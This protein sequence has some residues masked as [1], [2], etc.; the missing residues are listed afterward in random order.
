M[1]IFDIEQFQFVLKVY[2]CAFR[3]LQQ[4]P[5]FLR[6]SPNVF[7]S[8]LHIPVGCQVSGMFDFSWPGD[9]EGAFLLDEGVMSVNHYRDII[10][11]RGGVEA[12]PD[13]GE[14]A[15]VNN[16]YLASFIIEN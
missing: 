2:E 7:Q 3:K 15:Q 13:P 14:Y 12:G 16:S 10:T 9:T 11:F 4:V 8:C 1:K 5:C 6:Y